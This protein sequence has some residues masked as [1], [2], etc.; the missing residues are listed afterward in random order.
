MSAFLM[1]IFFVGMTD[2]EIF[3]LTNAMINSG[4][5][6]DLSFLNIPSSDK[7]STGG[8]GDGTSLIIV[9]VVASLGICVPMMAG[10]GLGSTGGTLDKLESIPG[11]RTN[12]DKKNF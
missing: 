8:I 10:R 1:S 2:N 6:I 7:H 4:E 12:I 11:F 3:Y 9:P 5:K